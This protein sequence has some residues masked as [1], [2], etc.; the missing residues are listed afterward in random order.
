VA[1]TEGVVCLRVE[2]SGHVHAR[3][4]SVACLPSSDRWCRYWREVFLRAAGSRSACHLP[5]ASAETRAYWASERTEVCPDSAMSMGV[6]APASAAWVW[7][8]PALGV[9]GGVRVAF[10]W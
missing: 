6:E 9:F 1:V 10:R 2:V 4:A 3:E 8:V 7:L 5:S